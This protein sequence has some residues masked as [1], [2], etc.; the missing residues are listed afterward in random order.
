MAVKVI[1]VPAQIVLSASFEIIFTLVGTLGLT[2]TWIELLLIIAG[3]EQVAEEVMSKVI[4][5]LFTR[6]EVV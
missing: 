5:S 4:I 6:E 2:V 1:L 3:D